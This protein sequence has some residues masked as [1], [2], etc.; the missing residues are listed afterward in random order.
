MTAPG[1]RRRGGLRPVGGGPGTGRRGRTGARPGRDEGLTTLEWLLVVAAVAGIAALGVVLV[2]SVVGGT[3]EQV[4][5]HSARQ[6]AAD[7]A[8]TEL[9]DA[10][11]QQR[12]STQSDAD[13]INARYRRRCRRLEI[14]YADVLAGTDI[15]EGI[16]D[17]DRPTGWHNTPLCS[18]LAIR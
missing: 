1:R 12:P 9:E 16:Y 11:Q 13:Q 6:E 17:P 10:W 3:A 5:S 2:Q 15:V 7:L 14:I 4:G 8:A 18:I